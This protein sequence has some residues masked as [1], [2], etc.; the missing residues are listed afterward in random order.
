VASGEPLLQRL[1]H[2]RSLGMG[3]ATYSLGLGADAVSGNP[4]SLALHRGYHAETSGAWDAQRKVG[5][6]SNS[7][8]DGITNALA[9]GY[10]YQLASTGRGEAR[11][12]THLNTLA[13][14]LPLGDSFMLGVAGRHVLEAGPDG[15]SGLS[16]SAGLALKLGAFQV[17]ASGHN[18]IEFGNP[19]FPR[20]FVGSLGL[21]T[22][23]VNLAADVRM[24]PGR[25]TSPYSVAA[26]GEWILGEALPL[27]GGWALDL[28][29]GVHAL[30]GGLGV[31][32][33]GGSGVDVGYQQE[34]GGSRGRT[35]VLTLRMTV[36]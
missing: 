16:G 13:L 23:V 1:A 27:R 12:L 29:T 25:A 24:Q 20:Y 35:L 36:N 21:V 6:L 8:S 4:A 7:V 19:D 30:S 15:K 34:L 3:G 10:S 9:A 32:V 33:G 14:A 5:L 22:G 28:E 18:L 17:G 2:A 31:L 11:H 26:G